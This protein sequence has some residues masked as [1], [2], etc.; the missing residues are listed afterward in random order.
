MRGLEDN[1]LQVS[2]CVTEISSQGWQ[3]HLLL[4]VAPQSVLTDLTADEFATKY[5]WLSVHEAAGVERP[6]CDA[7]VSYEF[8]DGRSDYFASVFFDDKGVATL[9]DAI[10]ARIK[11]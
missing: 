7:L 9:L 3:I 4:C 6:K 5:G 8:L 1:E 2:G 10:T 11:S